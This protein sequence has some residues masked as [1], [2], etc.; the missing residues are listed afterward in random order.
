[1]TGDTAS[2]KVRLG[3]DL[4]TFFNT[5]YWG[6]GSLSYVDW[7]DAFKE[8]PR[9]FFDAMLDQCVEAGLDGIEIAPDPGGWDTMLVAYGD[10]AG[11][12][13]ALDSRGLSV[14]SSYSGS[15]DWIVPVME[16]PTLATRADE[17]YAAH[18]RF[19]AELGCST[20]VTGNVAREYFDA[21]VDAEVARESFERVAEQLNRL[22]SVVTPYGVSV[23]VHSDAYSV[24]SRNADIATLMSLT[25]P[26][27][28][29]LCPDAG[30]ITLD[31]GDAAAALEAHVDRVPVMHWKDCYAPLHPSTLSG[32][33]MVQHET[34]LT[35]FR[36][37]GA[38]D[39]LVDWPR[40]QTALRDAD[41]C[42]WA[43]AEIDMSP[44]PVGEIVAGLTYFTKELAPIHT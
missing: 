24:C 11:V 40:W 20:I 15:A 35:Y 32:P 7:I 28:V 25:D 29:K 44:D 39:G 10:V 8:R 38:S 17:H 30:H 9:Y 13:A 18:A 34:M 43:M 2:R 37:L 19:L 42:G 21:D 36:V 41:W 26:A 14:G 12:K 23:A 6:L 5:E 22:G 3:T 33:K 16:D 27:S 1:M 4:I 31:G